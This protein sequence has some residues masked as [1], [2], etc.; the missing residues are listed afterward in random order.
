MS[1]TKNGVLKCD[2]CGKFIGWK[3]HYTWTYY[4]NANDYEP[5]DPNHAHLDCYNKQTDNE[6]QLTYRSSWLK[7]HQHVI[8]E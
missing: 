5:P 4:G 7:P 8:H 1:I 3:T 2:I 6:K